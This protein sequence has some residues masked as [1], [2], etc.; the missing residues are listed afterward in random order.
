MIQVF[1]QWALLIMAGMA[2][3]DMLK[4]DIEGTPAKEP[5][6]FEGVITSIIAVA[7]NLAL[8]YGA[9]ALDSLFGQR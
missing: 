7:I 3:L 6:G 9:G 5:K 8:L 1:C 4:K 2:F